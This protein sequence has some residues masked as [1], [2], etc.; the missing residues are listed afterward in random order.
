MSAETTY[1]DTD[2]IRLATRRGS[3]MLGPAERDRCDHGKLRSY[4]WKWQVGESPEVGE[5]EF[6][7][8]GCKKCDPGSETP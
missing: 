8:Y 1:N 4:R 5:A 2:R 6:I 3:W 7:S